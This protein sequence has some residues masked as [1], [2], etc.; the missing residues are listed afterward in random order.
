MAATFRPVNP[1]QT[2]E[3]PRDPSEE[4]ARIA[5]AATATSR[6]PSQPE[7]PKVIDDATTPT[8]E[9]FASRALAAQKP[10]PTSPFPQA[11]QMPEPIEKKKMPQRENSQHSG[12]SGESEDVDMDESDGE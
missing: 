1:P 3:A 5:V 11:V 9:S 8:R 12:K 6:S 7:T 2:A 4:A 10:L